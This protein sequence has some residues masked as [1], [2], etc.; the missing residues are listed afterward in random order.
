M[1]DLAVINDFMAHKR[2]AV[3]GVS[4]DPKGF[5]NIV[6]RELRSAGYD[7]V[8]VGAHLSELDGEPVYASVAEVPAPVE[9]V[10]VMVNPEAAKQ[11][12]RE[13]VDAGVP[14]VWLHQG[15]GRGCVSDEAVAYCREHKVPV[16]DGACPL[17]FTEHPQWFHR[18]HRGMRKMRGS[19]RAA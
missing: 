7:A 1:P 3:V 9:G 18:M 10:M 15:Y 13:A 5:A 17:M 6:V 19:F 14:R 8:P 16:V 2:F 11:V 4:Q 12:V